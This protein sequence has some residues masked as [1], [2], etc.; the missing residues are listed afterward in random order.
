M[1]DPIDFAAERISN[2]IKKL[3]PEETVEV[4]VMNYSLSLGMN[5]L[6]TVSFIM[7]IGFMTNTALSTLLS[8]LIFAVQRFFVKGFHFKS[9][10]L[11]VLVTTTL[12]AS[13]PHLPLPQLAITPIGIVC[14]LIILY[15]AKVKPIAKLIPFFVIAIGMILQDSVIILACAAQAITLV[16]KGGDFNVEYTRKKN[17]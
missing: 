15:K 13:I 5:L 10:T 8:F 14:T 6:L 7:A 11:C 9:L 1:T 3:N 4:E 12:I 16:P 2:L 17:C